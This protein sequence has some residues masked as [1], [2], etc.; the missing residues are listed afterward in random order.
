M[1]NSTHLI[2]WIASVIFDN[3]Q[4]L[5]NNERWLSKSSAVKKLLNVNIAAERLCIVGAV[6]STSRS[7]EGDGKWPH[8]LSQTR[9]P[10]GREDAI[11]AHFNTDLEFKL[12]S[13]DTLLLSNLRV[14]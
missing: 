12:V 5:R 9:A 11:S 2:L 14:I 7:N 1:R 10:L 13:S 8:C 4:L 6:T 3:N